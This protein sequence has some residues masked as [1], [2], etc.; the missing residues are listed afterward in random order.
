RLAGAEALLRASCGASGV[1]EG[2]I[3]LTGA[4]G[5]KLWGRPADAADGPSR[6]YS[7]RSRSAA[8]TRASSRAESA[9]SPTRPAR[10]GAPSPPCAARPHTSS[11]RT[12]AVDELLARYVHRR[13]GRL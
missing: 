11:A 7:T 10:T 4:A 13:L 6:R 3:D 9:A 1:Q 12:S 2:H 5:A 8:F